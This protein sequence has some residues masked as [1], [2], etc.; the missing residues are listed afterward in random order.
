MSIIYF[1]WQVD[2]L[3][4][5]SYYVVRKGTTPPWGLF[6][7]EE[8]YSG[9][10]VVE[11]LADTFSGASRLTYCSLPN[12]LRTIGDHCFYESGLKE[13]TIP[14]KIAEIPEWCFGYC[15]DL[16][17][18]YIPFSVRVI[19]NYAFYDC[20]SLT[21][22]TIKNGLEIIAPNAFAHLHKIEE[23]ILPASVREIGGLAFAFCWNLK[24][25]TLLQ[26]VNYIADSAFRD[27]RDVTAY[28]Y[29]N[30]YAKQY[31]IDHNIK[32]KILQGR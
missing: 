14:D 31:C 21:E 8:S 4:Y 19:K 20:D 3:T 29:D 2:P 13:I 16:Q 28:V 25:I 30:T 17:K 12:S 27:T 32:F 23:I 7:L 1:D 9:T 18:V 10:P 5:E 24:T 6:K 11:I 26:N 22:L 15:N